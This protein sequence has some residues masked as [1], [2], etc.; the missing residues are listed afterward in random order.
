VGKYEPLADY[1][2]DVPRDRWDASFDE[3]EKILKFKLPPSA[4]RHHSWWGNSFRGNHSQAKG[5]INAGWM[6][7]GVD[8]AN[9]K[10]SLERARWGGASEAPSELNELWRKAREISGIA[11]RNELER[12]AVKT[13]IRREAAKKLIALG[14]SDPNFQ[15]A[16]RER[17]F[18]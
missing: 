6:V 2:D 18:G 12:A 7:R 4:R 5:W 1:L 17:P 11:D 13:F 3:I 8:L 15:A 10:V 14:G 9:E 16:P